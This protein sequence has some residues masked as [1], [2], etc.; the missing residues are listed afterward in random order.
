MIPLHAFK[1]GDRVIFT[2][3]FGACWG[4]KT[5]IRL[6]TLKLSRSSHPVYYYTPTD[7]PWMYTHEY[8]L[9][10]ADADDAGLDWDQLQAKHGFKP[11]LEQ[12][13]GCY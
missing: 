11:T 6:D 12:L 1:V 7:T 5:I 13:G 9:K 2:N 8:N 4:V 3:D 10:L